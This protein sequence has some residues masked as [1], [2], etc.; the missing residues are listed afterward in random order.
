MG[1]L[2]HVRDESQWTHYFIC[3]NTHQLSGG[4][5]M[6][7]LAA[8]LVLLL[9]LAYAYTPFRDLLTRLSNRLGEW[10]VGLLLIPYL[11]AV[12]LRPDPLDVLR[13]AVYLALPTLFLRL[14]SNKSRPFDLFH[15]LA[16]LALWV[17]VETDLFLLFIDL[18]LPNL[19]L[20]A[21]LS[22]FYLLPEVE[23]MLLP[24]VTAVSLALYLFLIRHPLEGI[25]FSFKMNR[26]MLRNAMTGLTIFTVVG[27][28]LGLGMG[29]LQFNLVI[30]GLLDFLVNVLAGYLLVALIEEV[31]FRGVIQNLL[32]TRIGN[33]RVGLAIGS[34]IFGMAHL[35]NSTTGF[36]EPNWAYVLMA[37]I[38][39]LAYGWVWMRTKRVTASAI[40][41][42]LVNLVWDIVFH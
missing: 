29:F 33:E 34:I 11:L 20:G 22:G 18:I 6:N 35:N 1:A 32:I 12:N 2:A 8:W 4:K 25:G 39:G 23:V 13:L 9:Y 38:A 21:Q 5:K 3:Q 40:T 19:D 37:T 26:D 31:L 10:T 28:P 36:P 24:G 14:R 30:P 42:M 27:L 17:P 15:V 16:I 7:T 41:H